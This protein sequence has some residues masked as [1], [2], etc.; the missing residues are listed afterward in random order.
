MSLQYQAFSITESLHV[1]VSTSVSTRSNLKPDTTFLSAHITPLSR[2]SLWV[3][4]FKPTIAFVYW[5]IHPESEYETDSEADGG[6][7]KDWVG[8]KRAWSRERL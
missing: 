2:L 5:L 7:L 6:W 4:N 1:C 3:N 8:K